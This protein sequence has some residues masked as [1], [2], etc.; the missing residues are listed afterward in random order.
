VLELLGVEEPFVGPLL[1][2]YRYA[3]GAEVPLPMAHA[4]ALETEIMVCLGADLPPRKMAWGRD[5]VA[6]AVA[7]VSPSFEIV[8]ARVPEGLGCGGIMLIAD[9]GA[10][11]AFVQGTPVKSWEQ[12]DLGDV[13]LRVSINGK[14]TATGNSGVLLWRDPIEAV[15]WLANHRLLA[16]RGLRTGD[17]IMTGTCAGIV[18]I[19]PGD[20][21]V[22]DFGELGEVRALFR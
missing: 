18:A 21:A 7:A 2:R 16:D 20:E 15:V 19:Q 11:V 22:A 6:Q 12:H 8:G 5:Q 17:M 1:E 14:E 9:A 4:P 3:S 10:N 13:T